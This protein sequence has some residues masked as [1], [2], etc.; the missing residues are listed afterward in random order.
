MPERGSRRAKEQREFKALGDPLGLVVEAI[1]DQSGDASSV[2]SSKGAMISDKRRV[3]VSHGAWAHLR[4]NGRTPQ[5]GLARS[6]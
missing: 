4:R 6:R 2:M 1:G 3:P 5:A